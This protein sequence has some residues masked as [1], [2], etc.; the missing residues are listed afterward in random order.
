MGTVYLLKRSLGTTVVLHPFARRGQILREI[1][2]QPLVYCYPETPDEDDRSEILYGVYTFID[3]A[4]DAWI[5]ELKYIP[6]LLFSAA[7]FLLTYWFTALVI[8]IP[9]PLIDELIFSTAAATAVYLFVAKK[10]TKS[11]VAVKK[12][13]ELKRYADS[14]QDYPSAEL[15]RVEQ[16]LQDLEGLSP[17]TLAD[18]LCGIQSYDTGITPDPL[19][20]DLC[21]CLSLHLRSRRRIRRLIRRLDSLSSQKSRQRS[22]ARL[23]RLGSS[24]KVDLPLIALYQLLRVNQT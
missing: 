22:S 24:G 4:V 13:I 2:S 9:V 18:I 19:I 15:K 20:R 12:R 14:G 7:A 8:R 10:N 16:L 3:R 1:E 5:Q 6:R 21:R 23:F 11:E 17:L